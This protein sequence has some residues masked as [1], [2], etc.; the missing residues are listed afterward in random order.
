MQE[1]S[2]G[3]FEVVDKMATV[4]DPS[5]PSS[6]VLT[7][8]APPSA[9][10]SFLTSPLP[11][12]TPPASSVPPES[13]PQSSF[14]APSPGKSVPLPPSA[15][16]SHPHGPS[17][18]FT[19]P[20]SPTTNSAIP[21]PRSPSVP[22]SGSSAVSHPE[23]A[24]PYSANPGIGISPP[25]KEP[26]SSTFVPSE[27]SP[28]PAPPPMSLQSHSAEPTMESQSAQ[29]PQPINMSSPVTSQPQPPNSSAGSA[30]ATASVDLG[31]P[32]VVASAKKEEGRGWFGW[33]RGTVSN[34]G[35]RVAERA[36]TSMDSMITTLDPQMKE[37][38]HSGGDMDIIVASDKEVKVGAIREAFQMS[39]GKATVCGMKAE[40]QGIAAQPV[41][42]EA[43][44]SSAEGRIN[45][46]R[47]TGQI[48]PQHPIVAVENFIVELHS[49]CWFD[50]GLLLLD[51][52]GEDVLLQ[53][54][55]QV[56]P[57][58]P[59]FV[60]QARIATPEDY[61]L[62]ESGFAVTIGQIASQNLQ[63]HHSMWQ[64]ALTGVSRR[65]ALV[66]AGRT[67]AGLYRSRLPT[68]H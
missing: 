4:P 2:S 44:L 61:P 29:V 57:V 68:Y 58:P 13:F 67:L 27:V 60:N 19:S 10:P 66:L 39:F 9:L 23:M 37:F 18:P 56:T 47:S 51:D 53:T 36:K 6:S 31:S 11:S 3:G 55:T 8:V 43:A 35:H 15:S 20:A 52:P 30:D 46:L 28:F 41:G 7:N 40:A 50:L 5:A 45:Y 65:E 21:A 48:H 26:S 24:F 22:L 49:D 25:G 14:I 34:V 17:I 64:E 12:A 42:F 32:G 54:Y 1:N 62:K 59:D 33:I 38:L 63:V 16:V